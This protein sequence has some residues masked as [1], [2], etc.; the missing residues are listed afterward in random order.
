MGHRLSISNSES[1]INELKKE[2]KIYGP[3][4]VI[5]YNDFFE[6]EVIAYDEIN[7]ISEINYKEKS[8]YPIKEIILTI[9]KT[10]YYE[11]GNLKINNLEDDKG[12]IIFARACDINAQ[13]RQDNIYFKNEEDEFYKNLRKKVKF[14]CIECDKSFDNCFCVSMGSNKTNNYSMAIKFSENNLLFEVKDNEFFKYFIGSEEFDYK[15]RFIESNKFKVPNLNIKSDKEFEKLNNLK[16]W[17]NF[18]EKCIDCGKCNFVC[19]VCSCFATIELKKN[20]KSSEQ[21][22]VFYD[23]EGFDAMMGGYNFMKSQSEKIKNKIFSKFYTYKNKFG[24]PMCVGCGRCIDNCSEG[25]SLVNI[26][27]ELSE[28]IEK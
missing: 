23:T 26:V 7:S 27:N 10:I 19:S 2:Y 1:L 12:I 5:K 22:H 18:N 15:I 4:K 16:L 28:E 14:I 6:E 8:E 9:T 20:R 21:I 3:K 11:D 17:E 25:I 24:M 13:L